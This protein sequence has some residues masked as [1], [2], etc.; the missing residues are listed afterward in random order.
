MSQK[1]SATQPR[2]PVSRVLTSDSATAEFD[3]EI[4]RAIAVHITFQHPASEAQLPGH[5]AK[6]VRANPGKALIARQTGIRV[7][8]AQVNPVPFCH[9]EIGDDIAIGL[10]RTTEEEAIGIAAGG[11]VGDVTATFTADG[12]AAAV[13]ALIQRLAFANG[14]DTPTTTSTLTI[15]VRDGAEAGLGQ[16]QQAAIGREGPA[17][18]AGDDGLAGD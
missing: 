4:G 6:G 18:E 3:L 5:A 9:A 17:V 13:D 10:G 8:R 2:L 15:D 14:A 16:P 12:T 1:S 11:E 7:D